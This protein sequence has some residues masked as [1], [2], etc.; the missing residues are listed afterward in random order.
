MVLKERPCKPQTPA[1]IRVTS[2]NQVDRECRAQG[3]QSQ[4]AG[5]DGERGLDLGRR[6]DPKPGGG[7]QGP[8]PGSGP[9]RAHQGSRSVQQGCRWA[10]PRK[11][12]S[13]GQVSAN[14]WEKGPPG[15]WGGSSQT[16]DHSHPSTKR[17][18]WKGLESSSL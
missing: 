18:R 13:P 10:G 2:G 11:T 12:L 15:P 17:S 16:Q 9:D 6:R 14:F 7:D 3:K 5:P 1:V 8:H 4:E